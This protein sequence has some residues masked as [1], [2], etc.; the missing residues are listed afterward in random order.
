MVWTTLTPAHITFPIKY[1]RRPIVYDDC[2]HTF[3]HSVVDKFLSFTRTKYPRGLKRFTRSLLPWEKTNLPRWRLHSTFTSADHVNLTKLPSTQAL[4]LQLL[5]S[6]YWS[7]VL[8][9]CEQPYPKREWI[10]ASAINFNL[11]IILVCSHYVIIMIFRTLL[12]WG[13]T[14]KFIR[15]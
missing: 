6:S 1:Y 2:S 12:R 11:S 5:P 4:R 8:S 9:E 13:R 3:W 14:A 10:N 7:D 15:Y